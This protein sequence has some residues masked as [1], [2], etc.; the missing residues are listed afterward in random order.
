MTDIT[1]ALLG[2]HEAAERVTA[3]GEL[4]PC[5]WCGYDIIPELGDAWGY[6]PKCRCYGPPK[7]SYWEGI[8]AWNTRAP[9][10]RAE[11]MERLEADNA[12]AGSV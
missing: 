10:L 12:S 5:P 9:I 2:D 11:E 4:L 8:L 7:D 1:L 6:C 3:R